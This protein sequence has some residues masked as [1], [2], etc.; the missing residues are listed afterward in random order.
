[1]NTPVLKV[2]VENHQAKSVIAEYNGKERYFKAKK[3]IILCAG[4]LKC[5]I[6]KLSIFTFRLMVNRGEE[7]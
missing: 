5:F 6:F 1:M 3:E 4:R 2:V 7:I